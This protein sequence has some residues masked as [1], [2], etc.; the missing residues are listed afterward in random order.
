[1]TPGSEH[2]EEGPSVYSESPIA[3][4]FAPIYGKMCWQ[5][6]RDGTYL[7]FEFGDPHVEVREA[8]ERLYAPSPKVRF[9]AVGR[10][11]VVRGDWHLWIQ[12]CAWAILANGKRLAHSTSTVTRVDEALRVLNGQAL[13]RFTVNAEDARARFEFDLGGAL[14]T[15]PI[16]RTGD[17]WWL[18]EPS[19]YVLE[20]RADGKYRHVPA[21]IALPEHE[22]WISLMAPEA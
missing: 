1:M 10:E 18:F 15:R 13:T 11:A 21:D 5:G 19:G 2:L 22:Q 4:V 14:E 20:L 17:Q 12:D 8:K 3:R 9:R 6:S 16:D 7:T